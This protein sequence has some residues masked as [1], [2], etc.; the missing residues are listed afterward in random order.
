MS[1]GLKTIESVKFEVGCLIEDVDLENRIVRVN[2][3]KVKTEKKIKET[4]GACVLRA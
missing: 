1:S 4:G 2:K 3:K